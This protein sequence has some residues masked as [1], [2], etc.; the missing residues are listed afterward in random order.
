MN[1]LTNSWIISLVVSA[2]LSILFVYQGIDFENP[3]VNVG[4]GEQILI[5]LAGLALTIGSILFIVW[6]VKC[7]NMKLLNQMWIISLIV[8]IVLSFLATFVF[9]NNL[10]MST[11][12]LGGYSGSIFVASLITYLIK[13]IF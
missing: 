9:T 6:L 10:Q 8:T 13:Y 3:S 11:V 2:I 12:L 1:A 5:W 7:K 4:K